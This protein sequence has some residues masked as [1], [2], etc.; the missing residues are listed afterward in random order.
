MTIRLPHE[1]AQFIEDLVSAG[2]YA[3]EN[4]VIKDALVRLRRAMEGSPAAPLQGGEPAAQE[5]PLTKQKLQRHLADIGLV[6][7][8]VEAIAA[9]EEPEAPLVDEQGEVISD[10]VIRERLIE[11][12]A[13]FL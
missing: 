3:S 1:L 12:L 11:W 4:D 6:S 7:T 2:H 13:R 8:S 10:M 5:K 9:L